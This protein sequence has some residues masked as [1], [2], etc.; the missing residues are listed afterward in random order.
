MSAIRPLQVGVEL[1]AWKLDL[2]GP[3]ETPTT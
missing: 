2:A 1:L 3:V